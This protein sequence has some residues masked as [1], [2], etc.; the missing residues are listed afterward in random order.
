M[1]KENKLNA[2]EKKKKIDWIFYFFKY[3]FLSYFYLFIF[4]FMFL[5]LFIFN[6]RRC[7]TL[8]ETSK[9]P[10]VVRF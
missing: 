7:L 8:S 9:S 10:G 3:F 5:N 2:C 6:K 1:Y 4:I